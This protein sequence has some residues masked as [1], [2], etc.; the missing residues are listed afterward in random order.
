M[1]LSLDIDNLTA[2]YEEKKITPEAVIDEIYGR[3]HAKGVKPD[4]IAL[5]AKD[6][7][8]D[9]A[10]RAPRGPL[11]GIPFAVKDNIDVARRA[12]DVRL[13]SVRVHSRTIRDGR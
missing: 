9:R 10:R 2:L 5:F 13:P 11:F 8:K 7:A 4:W 12:D 6:V 1:T 3:I